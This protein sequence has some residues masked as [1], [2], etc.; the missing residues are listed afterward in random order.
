MPNGMPQ[1]EG[2]AERAS[3]SAAVQAL[4][5]GQWGTMVIDQ[6]ILGY[7]GFTHVFLMFRIIET[8]DLCYSN[9]RAFN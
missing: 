2:G 1:S 9:S 5:F 8:V 3:G 6:C 7:P 4:G